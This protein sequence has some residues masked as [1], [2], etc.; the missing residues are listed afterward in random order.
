MLLKKALAA[1]SVRNWEIIPHPV[2]ISPNQVKTLKIME[3]LSKREDGIIRQYLLSPELTQHELADKL[4]IAPGTIKSHFEHIHQKLN[5]HNDR[6]LMHW[7]FE[8]QLCINLK[9]LLAS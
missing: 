9:N 4:F 3:N 7:Y 6:E 5:V 1:P 2:F 8:N